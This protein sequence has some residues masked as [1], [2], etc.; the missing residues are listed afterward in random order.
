MTLPR[1]AGIAS[2]R[3]SS[4]AL[5]EN[6]VLAVLVFDDREVQNRIMQLERHYSPDE[7]RRAANYLNEQ[8][9]GRTLP[10]V[11]AGDPAPAAR[12]RTST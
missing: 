8:F 6:R 1:A 11:R 5:S 12:K 4:C 9:R 3:S 10:Q 2:R 7:L